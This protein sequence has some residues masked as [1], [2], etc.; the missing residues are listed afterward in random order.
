MAAKNV[1]VAWTSPLVNARYGL[2]Y[3]FQAW[4][5]G[6]MLS[7]LQERRIPLLIGFDSVDSSDLHHVMT[8]YPRLRVIL[9]NIPRLGRQ[10]VLESLLKLHS[11]LHLCFSPSFEAHGA[12]KDLC[13]RYGDHRWVWGMGYPESSPGAAITALT[14]SGLTARQLEAVAFGN[15]ERL[16]SEA[17][18]AANDR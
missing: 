18:Q 8:D 10:A 11:E 13:S 14:Y 6:D 1:A 15:V 17:K 9:L 3:R 16:L 2:Q 5:C 4:C 12:Y 7:A